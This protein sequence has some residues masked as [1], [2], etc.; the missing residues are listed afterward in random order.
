MDNDVYIN[1]GSY[2]LPSE[3]EEQSE[4]RRVS[5]SKAQAAKPMLEDLIA[6]FQADIDQLNTIS[7]IPVDFDT[8]PDEFKT[9]WLLRQ[10]MIKYAQDKKL[11]LES[12][13]VTT[14]R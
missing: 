6:V 12:L 13:L 8:M 3:P 14:K 10:E 9:A 1:D 5:Q 11:Y 7:S 2:Y 4:E